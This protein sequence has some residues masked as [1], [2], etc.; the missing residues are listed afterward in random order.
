MGNRSRGAVE[1]DVGSAAG[2]D[3][4]VEG[5]AAVDLLQVPAI[6]AYDAVVVGKG[7][8]VGPIATNGQ[9]PGWGNQGTAAVNGDSTISGAPGKHIQRGVIG[10]LHVVRNAGA[11]IL[12]LVGPVEAAAS[13]VFERGASSIGGGI[14]SHVAVRV[15]SQGAIEG[16]A[17]AKVDSF[18]RCSGQQ[19]N[20][21]QGNR[22]GH[23]ARPRKGDGL[24]VGRVSAVVGQSAIVG[25]GQGMAAAAAAEAAAL[26]D[27]QG[28]RV[29]VRV[30]RHGSPAANFH[31]SIA[32]VGHAAPGPT[33]ATA[34]VAAAAGCATR[35]SIAE[36]RI[37]FSPGRLITIGS[38]ANIGLTQIVGVAAVKDVAHFS[39][40]TVG[41]SRNLGHPRSVGFVVPRKLGRDWCA[42]GP[43][44]RSAIGCVYQKHIFVGRIFN[45][46]H[47]QIGGI[48]GGN[49][50]LGQPGAAVALAHVGG[51]AI[52]CLM[53]TI[54]ITDA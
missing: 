51:C 21:V 16:G 45:E 2:D 54:G 46:V 7:T 10:D 22:A 13:V 23:G 12:P 1:I 24:G 15:D 4:V 19:V 47:V 44:G 35:H 43:C 37:P 28:R 32:G 29:H 49:G 50:G 36:V 48:A 25:D 31:G 27:L 26:V 30:Q 3:Q 41:R 8:V 20:I 17:A 53:G 5:G 11:T 34:P 9:L 14:G 33:A 40:G 42:V 38:Y 52:G 6:E 18:G 39:T